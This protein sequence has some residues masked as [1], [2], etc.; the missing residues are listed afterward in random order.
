MTDNIKDFFQYLDAIVPEDFDPSVEG[1]DLQ[2]VKLVQVE[3]D[4]NN[5][6]STNQPG[7]CGQLPRK[8]FSKIQSVSDDGEFPMDVQ[9]FPRHKRKRLSFAAIICNNDGEYPNG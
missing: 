3:S 6:L 4:C 2:S 9:P 1:A 8:D 5:S 7:S